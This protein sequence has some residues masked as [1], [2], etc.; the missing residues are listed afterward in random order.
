MP[1][2][3]H[4]VNQSPFTHRA[5][6]QCLDVYREGDS[7]LFLNNGVYATLRSQP[8]AEN[9]ANLTCYSIEAD[10]IARGL[11]QQAQIPS[12]QL[13]NYGE[14]VRLCTQHALVQSWY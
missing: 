14:F 6:A 2:I 8:L 4:T 3:L 9:L 10:I 1:S 11:Q 7:I 13:I 12:L 5:L